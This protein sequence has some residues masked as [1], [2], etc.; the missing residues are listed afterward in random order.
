VKALEWM[1]S[2]QQAI[3]YMEAHLQEDVSAEDIAMRVHLSSYYFQR[4]FQI[5]TGY[6]ITEYIRCRRL[7]LAALE[8]LTGRSKIIDVALAYGYSTPDSFTKAFSRFH[9]IAPVQLR[10]HPE[11]LRT[12]LPLKIQLVI[13][14]GDDMNY[15]VEKMA[16]FQVIGIRQKV[17]FAA[18]Y[19]KIPAF[20]DDFCQQ[21][22]HLLQ[23]GPPRNALERAI[24]RYRIGTYGICLDDL[25]GKGNLRYLIAGV[26]PGGPVP[27]G[28]ET[29]AFPAMTWAK[30]RCDGPLPTAM[31][32]VNTRIF[33]EWLPNNPDY[34]IAMGASIEWYSQGDMQAADYHSEIWIPVKKR[35][36]RQRG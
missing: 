21:H 33:K 13:Q 32:A 8:V 34:D 12:F 25:P 10:E 36:D 3:A 30:F 29:M 22:G 31:Q 18:A 26:Y 1:S 28:L 24:Q 14:G 19:Q 11:K 17:A 15:T 23:G 2:L 16:A 35:E 7:Y 9:G 27:A 20:W 5:I 6:S 4:G